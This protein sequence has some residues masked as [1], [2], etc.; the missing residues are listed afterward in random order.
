[1]STTTFT[2]VID[3][4]LETKKG[5]WTDDEPR[6]I[7]VRLV[8]VDEKFVRIS[9]SSD[10][11]YR[12]QHFD[13]ECCPNKAWRLVIDVISKECGRTLFPVYSYKAAS[14]E[15]EEVTVE[16]DETESGDQ[17]MII[18][19]AQGL[20][21]ATVKYYSVAYLNAKQV[22]QLYYLLKHALTTAGVPFVIAHSF[23]FDTSTPSILLCD[24]QGQPDPKKTR[25]RR[26]RNARKAV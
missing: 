10:Y 9:L 4:A 18:E 13:I 25:R 21:A 5:Y 15:V 23:A 6:G 11:W 8:A 17:E 2:H 24:G 20:K 26:K 7:A 16:G 19:T 3:K 12:V 1:M 22:D 14:T